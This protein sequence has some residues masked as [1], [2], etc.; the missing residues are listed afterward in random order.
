MTLEEMASAIRNHIGD[1]LKEVD[2]YDYSIQ[3][4][5]DEIGLLR[6]K[7][8]Y[9]LSEAGK[10]DPNQF[11][12]KIEGDSM[13]IA[14]KPFPI[15]G[16]HPVKRV[17]H[18]EIPRPALTADNSAITYL[19]PADMSLDF[20]KY[21]DESFNEHKYNRVIKNRPYCFIDMANK[22]NGKVDAYFFG[23]DGS[24]LKNMAVRIIAENPIA[25]LE[26]DGV[27]GEDEEFPAPGAIQDDIIDTITKRYVYYYKQL[28]QPNEPNTN[29]DIH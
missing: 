29:T 13:V 8:I 3:Q 5:K 24:L 15:T 18:L 6:N 19:G 11:T 14:L 16:G 27:F 7:L 20:V 28:N 10:L 25:I 9:K 12:Q 23:L 4:I 22:P 21:Y 1:G 26:E 17:P 2:D